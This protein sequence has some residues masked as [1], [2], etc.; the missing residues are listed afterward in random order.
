VVVVRR[1]VV[2]VVVGR[3]VVGPGALVVAV[4]GSAVGVVVPTGVTGTV[5]G[6]G[7]V[8][9][10]AAGTVVLGR[11]LLVVVRCVLVVMRCLV[12][13]VVRCVVVVVPRRLW[14]TTLDLRPLLGADRDGRVVGVVRLVTLAG[15]LIV[16][17]WPRLGGGPVLLGEVPFVVT[18]ARTAGTAV[19]DGGRVVEPW[20]PLRGGLAFRLLCARLRAIA[21]VR[22]DFGALD[23]GVVDRSTVVAGGLA[24][25][26]VIPVGTG[27]VPFWAVVVVW[28]RGARARDRPLVLGTGGREYD[29]LAGSRRAEARPVVCPEPP[30]EPEPPLEMVGKGTAGNVVMAWAP[31]AAE[32]AFAGADV[33]VPECA[34]P[35]AEMGRGGL[36]PPLRLY[37]PTPIKPRRATPATTYRKIRSK[38]L[39][40]LITWSAPSVVPRAVPRGVGGRL[41]SARAPLSRQ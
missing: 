1:T 9:R 6:V 2:D 24:V 26:V 28:R 8:V 13:V 3:E 21:G 20:W 40:R 22:R 36:E 37:S 41:R 12:L 29:P 30:C 7:A 27:A 10:G 34:A 33:V 32:P 18:G 38:S 16:G 39:T 4:G 23:G 5:D 19:V 17:R 25:F 15:L 35:R 14:V 31:G 11:L